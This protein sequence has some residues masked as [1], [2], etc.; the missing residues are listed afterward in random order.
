MRV[1]GETVGSQDLRPQ[2]KLSNPRRPHLDR[3][4]SAAPRRVHR[5][6]VVLLPRVIA[7]ASRSR[8]LRLDFVTLPQSPSDGFTRRHPRRRVTVAGITSGV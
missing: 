7:G 2:P 3:P 5:A 4:L 8:I 6:T 1:A